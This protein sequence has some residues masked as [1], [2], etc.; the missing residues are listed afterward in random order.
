MSGVSLHF[1]M[2]ITS[3]DGEGHYG[4]K[5]FVSDRKE[6]LV[7]LVESVSLG[8]DIDIYYNK[9]GKIEDIRLVDEEITKK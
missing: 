5:A 2:P 6:D 7:D 4:D 1:I 9:Y 8:S 3:D